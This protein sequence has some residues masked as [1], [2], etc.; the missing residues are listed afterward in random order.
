[1]FP[2]EV[3]QCGLCNKKYNKHELIDGVKCPAC[4][5]DTSAVKERYTEDSYAITVFGASR[6]EIDKFAETLRKLFDQ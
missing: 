3:Y 6:E 1:L 5:E 2:T 4:N